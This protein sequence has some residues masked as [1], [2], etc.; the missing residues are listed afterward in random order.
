MRESSPRRSVLGEV[1]LERDI[2]VG[3]DPLVI[4]GVAE[5]PGDVHWLALLRCRGGGVDGVGS[6]WRLRE[7]RWFS[8]G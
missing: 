3:A 2:S 5:V 1:C 8:L 4:G 7:F 6:R